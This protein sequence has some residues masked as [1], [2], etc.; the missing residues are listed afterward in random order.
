MAGDRG[1]VLRRQSAR[2]LEAHH[3]VVIEQQNGGSIDLGCVAQR[4]Q[5]GFVYVVERACLAQGA[6]QLVKGPEPLDLG[7][8]DYT[9][10]RG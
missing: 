8:S 7:I 10:M 3:A 6:E 2:S 5:R 4:A 9:R 1:L